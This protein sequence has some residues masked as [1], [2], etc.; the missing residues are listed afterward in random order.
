M[1][2]AWWQIVGMVGDQ[3]TW[4]GESLQGRSRHHVGRLIGVEPGDD[5][6]TRVRK[7]LGYVYPDGS[8]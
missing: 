6:Q 3:L 8:E 1:R 7:L 5:D 2:F 4:W